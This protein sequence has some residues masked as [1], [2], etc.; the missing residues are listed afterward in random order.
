MNIA[1]FCGASTGTKE[2]YKEKTIELGKWIAKNNHQLV[3][4]GGNVGLM[5]IIAD[6]VLESKGNVIGVMPNFLIEREICHSGINELVTVENM[7]DRKTYIVENSDAFIA[8]PGGPGTLEEI[9]Q[10][11]SWARVGQND[12]PC[13][14][15]NVNGYYDYLERF[16]DTMVD[17]GFLNL[18]DREKTLFSD[19]LEEIEDFIK[20][21]RKP[22]VR[23]Y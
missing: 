4:G 19:N 11:I 14:L 1:V 15:F 7:S 20:N 9:S 2:I 21:Y 10:V 22:E 23:K 5:G 6:S 18:E 16:Y 3:Y 8:L 12:G 13:I 17:E